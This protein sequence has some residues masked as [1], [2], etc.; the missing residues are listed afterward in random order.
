MIKDTTYLL[1][2]QLAAGKKILFE[3]ANAT[4]LDVDHGTFPF[5]TSSS[6][7]VQGIGVGTGV[8]ER[9]LST[10]LGVMKAYSTR[11]GRG[12]LTTELFDETGQR[13]R[14]RGR[15]YG[16]TT[17][18]PRRVGWLDLVAVKYSAMLNG[19]TG[20]V[21]TL[22]DV[23]DG[24]PELRVATAYTINGKETTRFIPDGHTLLNAQPVY[25][26]LPGFSGDLSGVR[27]RSKLPD[28]ARRYVDFIERYVNV[29]VSL[30]GVG[31]GREQTIVCTR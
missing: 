14:E 26:T 19:C 18:R 16:T 28:H 21:L 31:P 11:V 29:P 2:D 6:C 30:I 22:L 12:P 8:P 4:L 3:G 25:T 23:L 5:V 15:E 27:E 20:L 13:I 24:L 17:G 1:H 9:H 10:V 7:A